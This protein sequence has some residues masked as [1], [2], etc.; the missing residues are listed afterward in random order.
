VR[1]W[2]APFEPVESAPF[3]ERRKC[4][5]VDH[6]QPCEHFAGEVWRFNNETRRTIVKGPH[7]DA[8]HEALTETGVI[9][10]ATTRDVTSVPA[11]YPCRN[12]VIVVIVSSS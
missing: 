8:L 1:V 7:F 2:N 10:D 3:E 4:A 11:T 5:H 6:G 9:A 12:V